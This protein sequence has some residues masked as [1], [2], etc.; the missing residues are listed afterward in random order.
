M[1]KF[2]FA[3]SLTTFLST[4]AMAQA[5]AAQPVGVVIRV[6]GLVTVSLENT[7]G[8]VFK[9]E[10]ILQG[11]RVATTSTGSTTIRLNNGCE[12]NLAPNQAVTIDSR[13][14]CKA[15]LAGVLPAG[16]GG[17]AGA[18][19]VGAT[20][21]APGLA[22]VGAFI[23]GGGILVGGAIVKLVSEG[24]SNAPLQSLSGS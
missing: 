13:L 22:G 18:G 1:N 10:T 14:D 5:P 4:A 9:D 7:L 11:A 6:E 21:I 24:S 23:V 8:N 12:V 17:V 19:A 2:T 3:L 20:G 16:T 15:L